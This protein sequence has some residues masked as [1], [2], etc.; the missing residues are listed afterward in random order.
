MTEALHNLFSRC[1][2]ERK[3]REENKCMYVAQREHGWCWATLLQMRTTLKKYSR[4]QPYATS[5]ASHT[6]VSKKDLS[7][8]AYTASSCINGRVKPHS[9][10]N[11]RLSA[12][13]HRVRDSNV[14]HRT[15]FRWILATRLQHARYASQCHRILLPAAFSSVSTVTATNPRCIILSRGRDHLSW[16]KSRKV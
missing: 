6:Y 8:A 15:R 13:G 16:W 1:Y 12:R 7:Q 9:S 10:R 11:P 3:T 14:S 4:N 2:F 5:L